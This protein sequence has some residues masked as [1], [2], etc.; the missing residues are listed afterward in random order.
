MELIL[1]IKIL[2]R[3]SFSFPGFVLHEVFQNL[4]CTPKVKLLQSLVG[5][6]GKCDS[7]FQL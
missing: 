2:N 4:N 6:R 5:V 3:D 1:E 7:V